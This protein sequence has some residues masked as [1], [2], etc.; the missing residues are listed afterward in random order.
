MTEKNAIMM[1]CTCGKIDIERK[2]IIN[3]GDYILNFGLD[4]VR[5]S[6]GIPKQAGVMFRCRS[7]GT[8]N[9]FETVNIE[10]RESGDVY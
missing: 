7:C 5:P 8:V 3:S 2:V 10:Y 6:M 4:G 1:G 9:T